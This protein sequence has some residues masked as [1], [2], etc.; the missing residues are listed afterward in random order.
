MNKW[1]KRQWHISERTVSWSLLID[2]I[3]YIKNIMA[4]GS[5]L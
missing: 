1:I 5:K 4:T 2:W 3:E